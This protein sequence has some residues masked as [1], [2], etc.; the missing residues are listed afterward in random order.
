[1]SD[2]PIHL[3][4][5]DAALVDELCDRAGRIAFDSYTVLREIDGFRESRTPWD[6][7][8]LANALWNDHRFD[9]VVAELDKLAHERAGLDPAG[10]RTP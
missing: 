2:T 6:A 1:M 9:P 4:P 8:R 10:W 3:V 5:M 7:R